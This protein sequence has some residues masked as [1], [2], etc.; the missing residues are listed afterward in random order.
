MVSRLQVQAFV[1]PQSPR[2]GP[3]WRR[4]EALC[5][6]SAVIFICSASY[7][8]SSGVAPHDSTSQPGS[9]VSKPELSARRGCD[10]FAAEIDALQARMHPCSSAARPCAVHILTCDVALAPCLRAERAWGGAA[11]TVCRGPGLCADA[12]ATTGSVA[13]AMKLSAAVGAIQDSTDPQD[14]LAAHASSAESRAS[15]SGRTFASSREEGVSEAWLLARSS[16]PAFRLA[17][18]SGW[19]T[20]DVGAWAESLG[21]RFAVAAASLAE[22]VLVDGGVLVAATQADLASFLEGPV[23][24]ER[25]AQLAKRLATD[26]RG[27]PHEQTA[28][29]CVRVG[30]CA[31]ARG[32]AEVTYSDVHA[33]TV[34]ALGQFSSSSMCRTPAHHVW[35]TL[36][37]LG[38]AHLDAKA[39]ALAL[40]DPSTGFVECGDDFSTRCCAD[41]VHRASLAG[42][43]MPTVLVHFLAQRPLLMGNSPAD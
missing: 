26:L 12:A 7:G 33:A 14:G 21:R 3:C 15:S 29:P 22:D 19:S 34:A 36:E 5:R 1:R 30:F 41:L 4:L 18:V 16:R 20:H 2:P 28:A 39:L 10:L 37:D 38:V 40:A 13:A 9:S 25:A 11:V 35:T 27:R 6:S 8:P 24:A 17:A 42:S 23:G 31:A 32:E 43:V